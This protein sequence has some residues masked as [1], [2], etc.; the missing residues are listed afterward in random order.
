MDRMSLQGVPSCSNGSGQ[1]LSLAGGHLDDVTLEH[2]EGPLQLDIE[3]AKVHRPGGGLPGERQ[4]AGEVLGR[5]TEKAQSVC[6]IREFGIIQVRR[7]FIEPMGCL[8][9]A[10][11]A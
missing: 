5:L 4:E 6:G 11:R 2:A 1:R 3:G 7:P 8:D 10:L 9:R